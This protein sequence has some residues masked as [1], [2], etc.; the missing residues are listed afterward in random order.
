MAYEDLKGHFFWEKASI[1]KFL[2]TTSLYNWI[3]ELSGVQCAYRSWI[4]IINTPYSG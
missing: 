1:I 3:L 4:E 2:W